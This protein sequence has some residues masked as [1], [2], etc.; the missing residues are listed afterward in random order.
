[1][2]SETLV[3][4]E[5]SKRCNILFLFL[6]FALIK[7]YWKVFPSVDKLTHGHLRFLVFHGGSGSSKDEIREAV[8]NGVVKMNVDTDTQ[9]G[10]YIEQVMTRKADSY[11]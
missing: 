4:K 11:S 7:P 9:V 6:L 3:E 10:H 5:V 1:V 2:S 8:D